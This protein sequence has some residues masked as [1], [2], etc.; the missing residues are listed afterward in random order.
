M[1]G[2]CWVFDTYLNQ[3]CQYLICLSR[4]VF[5]F[6]KTWSKYADKLCDFQQPTKLRPAL[7]CLNDLITNALQHVPDVLKYMSRI[8]NQS[9]FNFCAIPQVRPDQTRI[10]K[11][12][13]H[14]AQMESTGFMI[15]RLWVQILLPTLCA[16]LYPGGKFEVACWLWSRIISPFVAL[17]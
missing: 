9:V 16:S 4:F 1:G 17:T 2:L 7:S 5:L 12:T 14:V 13:Q 6:S 10:P 15:L 8:K 11:L 3:I